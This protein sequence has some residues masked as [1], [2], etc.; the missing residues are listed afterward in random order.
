MEPIKDENG[1]ETEETK[2]TITTII[3]NSLFVVEPTA[4]GRNLDQ[5]SPL[6]EG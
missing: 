6:L 5:S 1:Q 2:T 3:R 4:R